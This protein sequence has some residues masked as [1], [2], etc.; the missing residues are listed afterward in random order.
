MKKPVVFPEI[1][2]EKRAFLEPVCLF[3]PRSEDQEAALHAGETHLRS[4]EKRLPR[5]RQFDL[6]RGAATGKAFVR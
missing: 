5:E 3:S 4:R 6:L 1:S 2:R